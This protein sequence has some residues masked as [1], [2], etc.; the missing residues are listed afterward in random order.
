MTGVFPLTLTLSP[1]TKNVLR[2]REQIVG[3]LPQG[4]RLPPRW[5]AIGKKQPPA[6]SQT[7]NLQIP[8]KTGIQFLDRQRL[9]PVSR[10]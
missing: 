10:E 2:E 1:N 7:S 8:A 9:P 3:T 4:Y 6:A 5:G